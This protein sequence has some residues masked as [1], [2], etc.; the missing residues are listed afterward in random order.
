MFQIHSTED[1]IS[2][3]LYHRRRDNPELDGGVI[4]DLRKKLVDAIDEILGEYDAS[5]PYEG[6]DPHDPHV[7]AAAVA[8]QADILLTQD[9]GFSDDSELPYEV[10]NCDDFFILI[11]DS[12]S[13][14]VQRVVAAQVAYWREKPG[15]HKSLADALRAAACPNFADRVDAHL[16]ILSGIPSDS[17]RQQ[18]RAAK[19]RGRK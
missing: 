8:S 15:K 7:H 12:A 17:T 6:P 14:M 9:Q 13:W 2:E 19:R 16:R 11:D 5:I 1:V 18:R 4:T 10:F 3:T